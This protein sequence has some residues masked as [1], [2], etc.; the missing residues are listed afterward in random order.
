MRGLRGL[1]M[2]GALCMAAVP[3]M[4]AQLAPSPLQLLAVEERQRASK[5]VRKKVNLG[6]ADTSPKYR[7]RRLPAKPKRRPN[8]L[9]ISKR[10][11]HRHRRRRS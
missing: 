8:R 1:A 2:I 5:P 10:V 3:A 6:L 7:S 11:R 4:T 9:T